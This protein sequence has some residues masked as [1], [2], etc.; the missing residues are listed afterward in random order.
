[1]WNIPVGWNRASADFILSSRMMSGVYERV[2]PM[3]ISDYETAEDATSR[4]VA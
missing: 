1:M 2:I 4:F 3:T